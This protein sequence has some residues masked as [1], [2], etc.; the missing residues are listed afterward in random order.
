[1]LW[2][3][4]LVVW[5]L[6]S[7]P[8]AWI[9]YLSGTMQLG[10][11]PGKALADELGLWA[12]RLLL[13]VLSLRPLREITGRPQFVQVRQSRLLFAWSYAT[14]HFCAGMF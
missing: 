5:L 9:I 13:V 10:P 12:L 7:L 6:C 1:M 3:I 8:L 4:K 14:L 11:D 2:L